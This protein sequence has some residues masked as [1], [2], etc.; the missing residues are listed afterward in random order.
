MDFSLF[1][2]GNHVTFD[3]RLG[4]ILSNSWEVPPAEARR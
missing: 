2:V 1:V 4:Q 3:Q